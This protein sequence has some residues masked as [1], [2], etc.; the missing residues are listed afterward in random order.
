[1]S[2]QLTAPKWVAGWLCSR[3][4]ISFIFQEYLTRQKKTCTSNKRKHPN[5]IH[6]QRTLWTD[7]TCLKRQI[8]R[9]G[10]AWK[11]VLCLPLCLTYSSFIRT[12][13]TKSY[14]VLNGSIQPIHR[15]VFEFN[16]RNSMACSERYL[17]LMEQVTKGGGDKAILRH[18]QRNKKLLV[19]DRLQ[20]LL[21]KG[22]IL[23][24][25]PFAG[26]GMPYGD[27][28][29][30]GCI[31]GVG[32]VRDVWCVFIAND[33]TIKGGTAYPITVKKQLR[34]QDIAIQ[35]GL[36][37]IYLVDSGGAFLPLQA[38]IFPDKNHGGRMFYNEA[39]M[40]ALGIP[41]VAVVCGSCTAGG[42]YIPTMAEETVMVDRIGT[43]FLAGPPLVK[44]ATGEDVSPEELGGASLHAKISGCID[45]FA[46]TEEEAYECVRNIIATLNLD[47]PSNK[48]SDF[49]EPLYAA[50]ELNGLAPRDYAHTLNV[51]LVLSRLT[52][53]S[54]F[55]EFKAL[56]GTTL[57]TGFAQIKGHLV[58]IVA[59]NGELTHNASL[60][61]SHFV[62]L[63]DQRDIPIIFLQNTRSN[64]T[65]AGTLS[66]AEDVTNQLKAQGTMISAVACS[67]VPKITIIIGGCYGGESF[68][69]CGRSFDPN[70]LFLWPNARIG[71][72]GPSYF[73]EIQKSDGE[74]QDETQLKIMKEMLENE[75]SAFHSSSRVWDDGIILPKDTRMVIGQCLNIIKQKPRLHSQP[76]KHAVLRM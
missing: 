49:E 4:N 66:K 42:A 38:D 75:S 48:I 6:A 62:Q 36:P 47:I 27:I 34:A 40:S 5:C 14:P 9:K 58:G 68:P 23:E 29:A 20:L 39:V 32:K 63:C 2:R 44:A 22:E 30:A 13:L 8:L 57:V 76:E 10:I 52:D 46:A 1:M 53:G 17:E 3:L 74:I 60:K 45:H 70:F 11:N 21:D 54:K 37:C 26:L 25:S 15:H 35:N 7:H 24:L 65:M 50:E 12:Y 41:Q 31:T 59:N 43:I 19:R 71:L 64:V 55:L 69:M 56:Y 16:L 51:K 61:G 18:T 73:R 67:T 72:V 33:A 28:P